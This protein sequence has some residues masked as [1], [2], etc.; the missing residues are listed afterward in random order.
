[1]T[2]ASCACLSDEDGEGVERGKG[3]TVLELLFESEIQVRKVREVVATPS[4]SE[5][6]S[7]I[8]TWTFSPDKT[9]TNQKGIGDALDS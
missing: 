7:F 2:K 4:L 6:A 3:A 9:E 1:M 8:G 5:C